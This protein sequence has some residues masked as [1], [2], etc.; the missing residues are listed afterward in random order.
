V[1]SVAPVV[2]V[3]VPTLLSY[4][5]K[6]SLGDPEEGDSFLATHPSPDILE[7][8]II[9]ILPGAVSCTQSVLVRYVDAEGYLACGL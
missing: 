2:E 7:E 6:V 5:P 1:L 4:I 8:G 9:T 3:D